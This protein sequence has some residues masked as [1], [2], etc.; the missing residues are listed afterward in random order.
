[1]SALTPALHHH[2]VHRGEQDSG[3]L[4]YC[5]A[6]LLLLALLLSGCAGSDTRGNG[7]PIEDRGVEQVE[8]GPASAPPAPA[9][10]R[11]PAPATAPEAEVGNAAKGA[12]R[13]APATQIA[14][15]PRPRPPAAHP[16]TLPLRAAAAQAAERGDWQRAQAALERALKL[17]PRDHALWQQLA[18]THFRE[19]DLDQAIGFAERALSLAEGQKIDIRP[20]LNLIADIESARGNPAASKRARNRAAG[21]A[22][23][24]PGTTN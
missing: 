12:P 9:S 8:P 11:A 21:V 1:M 4:M 20:S 3:L 5:A 18:Y 17:D 15:A 16:A 22:G 2:A 14:L 13:T 19:G 7:A 6:L 10:A 23:D 24:W